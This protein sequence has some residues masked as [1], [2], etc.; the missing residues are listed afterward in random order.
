MDVSGTL[1]AVPTPLTMEREVDESALERVVRTLRDVGVDGIVVAGT[2][3]EGMSIDRERRRELLAATNELAADLSVLVGCTGNSVRAV[4]ASILD[5]ADFMVDAVLVPPPFYY[6]VSDEALVRFYTSLATDAPLPIVLYHIPQRTKNLLS[7]TSIRALSE[8]EEIVGIKDS[9]GSALF[10]LELLEIQND[11]F[12]VLQGHGPLVPWSYM[13]GASGAV[14]PI[15]SLFPHVE[16]EA[17]TAIATR[18]FETFQRCSFQMGHLAKLLRFGD[19]PLVTNLKAMGELLGL[20][21]RWTEPPTP[22]AQDEHLGE[23]RTAAESYDWI[24]EALK[25]VV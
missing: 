16:L 21:R 15:S 14:T 23:M 8:H 20:T 3:G 24:R 11:G 18:D 2:S 25:H 6:P 19:L 17:R 1:P 7:S 5:A 13:H 10:H 4:Q 22:V 12:K 9:L